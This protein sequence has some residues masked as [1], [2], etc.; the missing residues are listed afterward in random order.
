MTRSL[1]VRPLQ[2]CLLAALTLLA[3]PVPATTASASTLRHYLSVR[4]AEVLFVQLTVSEGVVDGELYDD[5]LTGSVPYLS[6]ASEHGGLNGTDDGGKLTVSSFTWGTVFGSVSGSS[7][8]LDLPQH[9]GMLSTVTFS[10]ASVGR[11]NQLLSQWQRWVSA[12]NAVDED[13]S[14]ISSPGRLG[15]DE[16]DI[17]YD[18]SRVAGDQEG[19]GW[20]LPGAATDC[21]DVENAYDKANTAYPDAL[22]L[23]SD[24]KSG[25][26]GDLRTEQTAL[27][28]APFD[29]ATY[30]RSQDALHG[31]PLTSP[32]PVPPLNVAL[33]TGYKVIRDVVSRVNSDIDKANGYVAQAYA[34]VNAASEARQCGPWPLLK[35]PVIGHVTAKWLASNGALRTVALSVDAYHRLL[36]EWQRW[37]SAA[38]ALEKDLSLIRLP[39]NV[40]SDVAFLGNDLYTIGHYDL[41]Q[42]TLDVQA[43]PSLACQDVPAGYSDAHTLYTA[44]RS[45][46]SDAK[47]GLI[48]D[49][50]AE[51]KALASASADWAAYQRARQTLPDYRTVNPIPPL[52]VALA[53][54]QK[55]LNSIVSDVDSYIDKANGYVA[56]AYAAVNAMNKAHSCGPLQRT[57][58]INHVT[59]QWLGNT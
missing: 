43:I 18:V 23:L 26:A 47:S 39:G 52:N 50:R 25:I 29:W 10:S 8:S 38:N 40:A 6:L 58:I 13:L 20:D 17:D 27:A 3:A 56:Q 31:Y 9:N 2:A 1:K 46:V 42:V 24:A 54:A 14:V 5:T 36:S 53:T 30:Q 57:P 48:G 32:V 35:A 44:G 11:Y 33:A 21:G 59:A 12:S 19:V 34:T 7:L 41:E 28:A 45:M 55:L 37:I 4:K 49:V 51:E 15:S 16:R 22:S